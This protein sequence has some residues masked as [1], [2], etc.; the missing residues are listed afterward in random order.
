MKIYQSLLFIA[1]CLTS[2]VALA[3]NDSL[4]CT[5]IAASNYNAVALTDDGTCCY[6]NYLTLNAESDMF[7]QFTE[8]APDG[9]EFLTYYGWNYVQ[10]GGICLPDGC[11]TLVMYNELNLESVAFNITDSQGNVLIDG[12]TTDGFYWQYYSNTGGV[13]GCMYEMACNYDPAATCGNAGLCDFTSC[14]GPSPYGCTNPE[15]PN[16]N[17]D[18]TIDDGSCCTIES[19]FS[20]QAVGIDLS[21]IQYTLYSSNWF[22]ADNGGPSAWCLSDG[23][24]NLVGNNL[25]GETDFSVQVVNANGDVIASGTAEEL[26]NGLSFS[27]NAVAGCFDYYACNYNPEATCSDLFLCDYSCLGCTNPEALNYDEVATVDDGSC[28]VHSY[29]IVADG[30]FQWFI[31]SSVNSGSSS[32]YY[33]ENT[34][35]CINDGCY[36]FEVWNYM[37]SMET[38]NW[39]IL[40]G[41]GNIAYSGQSGLWL[42]TVQISN[43]PIT[44]C[45]DPSAC[46][47]NS[48]ATCGDYALCTFDCYGCTDPLASNFNENAIFNNGLCCY[49]TWYTLEANAEGFWQMYSEYGQSSSAGNYP[50]QNGFCH[51]E[52]CFSLIF[53]PNFG[54]EDELIVTVTNGEGEVIGTGTFD[55]MFGGA[56]I[57]FDNGSV[58]GCTDPNACNFDPEA[59]CADYNLCN[60]GCY[61]CTNPEAPNY[62]PEASVD[63]GSCCTGEWYTIELSAEAYWSASASDFTT[64]QWGYYPQENGFCSLG[65]C[66]HFSAWSLDGSDLTYTI[67]NSDGVVST[68]NIEYYDYGV[69][70]SIGESIV[71]CTDPSSCNYN[72]EATCSDWYNCD[73]SC[74]GCTNEEAP[75]YDPTATLDDGSCCTATWY[76]VSLSGS[77]YWYAYDVN[78][79]GSAGVYPE[80]SGFC[81]DASCF[82]FTVY[83]FD[84]LPVE[85][86]ITDAEGNEIYNGI[87]YPNSF[88]SA[89]VSVSDEVAGC[90]D[91]SAC[92]FNADATCNDGS[93]SYYCG[94]CLD[95]AAMNYNAQALFDDGS[96]FYMAVPPFMGMSIMEDEENDQFYILMNMTDAGNG[97]P[98]A[99]HND[100]D[101]DVMMLEE[102]GQYMVGPYPCNEAVAFELQSMPAGLAVYLNAEVE[103]SCAASVRVN[104]VVQ[105]ASDLIAYPN[106]TKGLVTITGIDGNKARILLMDLSGRIVSDEMKNVTN[107]M[108]E[109]NLQTLEAGIYAV[110]AITS[111][112]QQS[113][114]IVLEQ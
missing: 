113:V 80:N 56:Y 103:G 101:N 100:F 70:I 75:N 19:Y 114:R 105:T 81:M 26:A 13:V 34:S 66:F 99:M 50:V 12:V 67:S 72:P 16:Y 86:I 107:G 98:Y 29:T 108:V 64:Y 91:E 45:T 65:D 78:Y 51:G 6:D 40:D 3:Q 63:D 36:N 59:N 111:A 90:T 57:L 38:I 2:S 32:G 71:G 106:P 61:G 22:I 74:Y 46:N 87:A 28:C 9:A 68:G 89:S 15:A 102:S 11:F 94:G 53:Y 37:N 83:A 76:S 54:N 110:Q 112:G 97:A 35:F 8:I 109:M 5:D 95:E 73:Y 17:A 77:A 84:G 20:L 85:V 4:G 92:N 49:G 23:C 79:S 1:M 69:F 14:G 21:M 47:F 42:A 31:S 18:A 24:Y 7:F 48:D 33:P 55:P 27:L 60:Y 88:Q 25:F 62:N 10:N 43:N 96:C 30:P 93:C 104:E 44:G 58:T 82:S 41:E 39:Q 52:G